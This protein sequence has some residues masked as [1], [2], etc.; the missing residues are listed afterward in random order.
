MASVSVHD[1]SIVGRYRA[2]YE[3]A[4]RVEPRCISKSYCNISDILGRSIQQYKGIYT[5][6]SLRLA[7]CLNHSPLLKQVT[8][9]RHVVLDIVVPDP[10]CPR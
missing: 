2:V 1:V 3:G 4:K 5:V 9:I 6:V 8:R 7:Y 10:V